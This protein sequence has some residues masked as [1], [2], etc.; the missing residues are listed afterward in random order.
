MLLTVIN[1]QC[2]T[3]HNIKEHNMEF[4]NPHEEYCFNTATSFSAVRG[5]AR[6]RTRQDFLTFDD[7]LKYAEQFNDKKTMIYAIND[8]GNNAHICNS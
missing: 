1:K 7:A 3:G 8:L 4:T 6:T 2:K 5:I